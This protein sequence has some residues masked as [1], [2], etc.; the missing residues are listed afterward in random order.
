LIKN[1]P[2]KPL[3]VG[4]SLDRRVRPIVKQTL[5]EAK[6]KNKGL[7]LQKVLATRQDSPACVAPR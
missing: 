6:E 7:R 2:S 3:T 5:G 1:K 4:A